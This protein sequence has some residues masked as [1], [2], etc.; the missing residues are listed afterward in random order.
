MILVAI[1]N[2]LIVRVGYFIY[3]CSHYVN[4]FIELATNE[5]YS[6]EGLAEWEVQ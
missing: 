4:Q 6:Y 2:V 1:I 5:I 3:Q